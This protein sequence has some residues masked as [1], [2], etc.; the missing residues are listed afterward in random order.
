MI[1]ATTSRKT[2]Q[3]LAR[4]TDQLD[5]PDSLFQAAEARYQAVAKWLAR[6]ES[7][8]SERDCQVYPQ[9]SFLLGT[10]VKPVCDEDQYDID[11]VCEV[12]GFKHEWT[13]AEL[14]A[15]I[16]AE[17]KAYARANSM[18]TPAHEGRRCWTLVYA[19]GAQFHMDILPALPQDAQTKGWL[20]RLSVDSSQADLAIAITDDQELNY[21]RLSDD[22]P[23][24]NPR[25]FAEWFRQRG[26]PRVQV[27][28][29]AQI[30]Q[31]PQH[32]R[33]TVLQRVVQVLKRHRDLMFAECDADLAPISVIISTL[34]ARVYQGEEDLVEAVVAVTGHLV[35]SIVKEGGIW[36]VRNPVNPEENFA[37]KWADHPERKD[38]FFAWADQVRADFDLL[39]DEQDVQTFS[40]RLRPALGERAIDKALQTFEDRPGRVTY[41]AVVPV[42]PAP[43]DRFNLPHRQKPRW[44]AALRYTASVTGEVTTDGHKQRFGSDGPVLPKRQDL[45]FLAATDAPKPF[46]VYWQVVNTGQEAN[47]A[48]GLRG[49]FD[50]SRIAGVG[51]LHQEEST[52]YAGAHSIECFIV[53]DGVCVARSGPFVVNI[54]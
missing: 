47:Q 54:E 8:V 10:V 21:R 52:L 7:S 29:E 31:V 6:P 30:S 40:D 24:S 49:G 9:G 38:A 33:R 45:R 17:I 50:L 35:Q 46:E 19:D 4:L 20:R 1:A 2:S 42:R 26:Q 13:Q 23:Q 16:G 41:G 53:K 51:G 39:A 12:E 44:P 37:D 34:A 3:L 15:L 36:L 43:V 18:N 48:K 22:W 14:K 5:I 27:F 11:L 25:G 32:R 28:A